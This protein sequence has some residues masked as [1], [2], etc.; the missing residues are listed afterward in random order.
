[1]VRPGGLPRTLDRPGRLQVVVNEKKRRVTGALAG[2]LGEPDETVKQASRPT[3]RPRAPQLTVHVGGNVVIGNVYNAANVPQEPWGAPGRALVDTCEKRRLLELRDH[4]AGVSRHLAG[5]EV[6][7]AVIMRR[8]ADHMGVKSYADI[9]A[10]RFAQAENYLVCWRARLEGMPGSR[11][12]PGTRQRRVQA[13][14]ALCDEMRCDQWRLDHMR[15][16]WGAESMS[17]LTDEAVE[18]LYRAVWSRKKSVEGRR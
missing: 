2:L 9:P 14:Y 12:S 6:T 11:R 5:H 4:I 3:W 7:P 10:D 1:M 8:L 13:I 18:Q 17:D 15:Q 16:Q